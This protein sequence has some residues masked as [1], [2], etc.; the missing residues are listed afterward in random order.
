MSRFVILHHSCPDEAPRP[1][2]FD[3]MLERGGVLCTWAMPALMGPG[4]ELEVE[5]LGDHR[6]AYL[7]YE[8]DISGNRGHVTRYDGGD[9]EFLEY[10]DNLVIAKLRG[11]TVR[12][13]VS[14]ARIAS[15]RW[16]CS[17]AAG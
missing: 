3:L 4:I 5:R 16:L 9:C 15:Q 6:L 17:F 2:H 7:T 1:S 11:E 12:G 8:G 13:Q 14:L 10:G